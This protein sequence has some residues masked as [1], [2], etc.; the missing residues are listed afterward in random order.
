MTLMNRSTEPGELRQLVELCGE[1]SFMLIP[2]S[3]HG[4]EPDVP[5]G[6]SWKRHPLS[7][8]E[9]VARLMRGLN[10]GVVALGGKGSLL[11]VDLDDNLELADK[12]PSTLTV[13]TRNGGLQLQRG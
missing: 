8:E 13:K 12:L 9:A 10:V 4:K 11:F 5:K 3:R 6:S 1:A 7:V 2:L